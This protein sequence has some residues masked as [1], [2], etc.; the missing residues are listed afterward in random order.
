MVRDVIELPINDVLDINGWDF[1]KDIKIDCTSQI[2]HYLSGF[3]LRSFIRKQN[4]LASF[5]I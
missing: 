1:A 2:Q 3:L 5:V 4:L